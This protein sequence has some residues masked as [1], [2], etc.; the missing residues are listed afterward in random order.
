MN[1]LHGIFKHYFAKMFVEDTPI[2]VT[3]SKVLEI[4]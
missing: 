2:S 3:G 1:D 4:V